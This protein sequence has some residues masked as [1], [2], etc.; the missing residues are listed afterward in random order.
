MYLTPTEVSQKLISIGIYTV[1]TVP[2]LEQLA[3]LLEEIEERLDIWLGYHPGRK[4]YV[5]NYRSSQS[6][7]VTL[8]QYPVLLVRRVEVYNNFDPS[9]PPMFV[10][11]NILSNWLQGTLLKV[12]YPGTVVKVVYDA[13]YDPLPRRFKMAAFTLLRKSLENTG[14][15]GDLSFF[16]EPIRD[17]SSIS[18]PGISKSFRLGGS[19]NNDGGTGGGSILDRELAS[20]IEAGDRRLYRLG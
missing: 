8:A 17:V 15:T 18:V 19:S 7:T 10:T 11:D 16:S 9:A 12:E 6:G 3:Y 5:E 1:D 20:L 2:T 14:L 13:G 4:T